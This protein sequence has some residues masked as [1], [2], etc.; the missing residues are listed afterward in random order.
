MHAALIERSLGGRM[1][2]AIARDATEIE[3]R[4]KPVKTTRTRRGDDRRRPRRATSLRAVGAQK[5]QK[6]AGCHWVLLCAVMCCYF[7][8]PYLAQDPL[9]HCKDEYFSATKAPFWTPKK[10]LS[11]KL[12]LSAK[13]GLRSALGIDTAQ[14]GSAVAS[15]V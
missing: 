7:V 9:T 2:G 14:S 5:R 11:A 3:A 15:D 10:M 8:R 4:E 12:A 13:F 6:S 1:I